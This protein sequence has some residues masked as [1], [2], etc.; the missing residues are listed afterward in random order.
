MN[1][2]GVLFNRLVKH[3]VK[4]VFGYPGGAILP[5]LNEFYKQDKIKYILTRTETGGSFMAEG[6]AKATKQPGV[7]MVT[8]GP[9][10]INIMTSLQNALSDGTPILGLTGQV[11]TTVLGT[12]AF[13]E[14]DIIGISKPCTK[15]NNMIVDPTIISATVDQAF[16]KKARTCFNRFA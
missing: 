4:Y 2:A 1:G 7:I 13:Q 3:G 10:A 15:W 5:V 12:D 8:S 14:A 9:G 6:Y 16:Y 11:S